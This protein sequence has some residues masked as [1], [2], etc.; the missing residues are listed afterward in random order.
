MSVYLQVATQGLQSGHGG[1]RPVKNGLQ[2][3]LFAALGTVHSQNI[4]IIDGVLSE[5]A[6]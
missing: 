1:Q 2:H 4:E 3:V 5:A 6:H